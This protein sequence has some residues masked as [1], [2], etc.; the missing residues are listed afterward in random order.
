MN[1]QDPAAVCVDEFTREYA[2]VT[3][4]TN[5]IDI[6]CSQGFH[7]FVIVFFAWA[8][9]TLNKKRFNP[10]FTCFIQTSRSWLIADDDCDFRI[11]NSSIIHRIGQRHHVRSATGDE[12]ANSSGL[13]GVCCGGHPL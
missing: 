8:A 2:H 10:A 5:E 3:R 4:E 7:D 6:A 9:A 1:V 12:N 11:C 13:G